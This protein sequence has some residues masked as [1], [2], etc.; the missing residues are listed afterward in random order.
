MELKE[1]ILLAARK[2]LTIFFLLIIFLTLAIILSIIQ[3]FKYGASSQVLVIQNFTN[4]DPYLTS[5]STEYLSNILA[6]VIYSN[7]F[8]TNVLDA[9]YFIDKNYFGQTVKAQMKNWKKT[10]SAKAV[11]DSG[12]ISLNV[13][14]TDRAQAELIT[15]AVIYAL[16]TKHGLYHGGSDNVS[17][18]I[19]DEPIISAYP[20]KPN[21]ILNFSLALVL[22]LIFSL[23]YVYLFPEEKYNIKLPARASLPATP[24]AADVVFNHSEEA[25][26]L[27]LSLENAVEPVLASLEPEYNFNENFNKAHNESFDDYDDL[28]LHEEIAQQGSMNNILGKPYSDNL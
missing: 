5:K 28:D 24:E 1:F 25:E 20:V 18:K 8:F 10:V 27:A 17:V 23:V 16:Q 15:R 22:G 26:P 13:Y 3:P 2:K 21:L 19:I 14:H 9:G 7:S 11:N 6:K 12:I 4:P